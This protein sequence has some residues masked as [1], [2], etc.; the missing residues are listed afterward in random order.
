MVPGENY[1]IYGCFSLRAIPGVSLSRSL[2]LQEITAA[3]I[4]Q[5]KVIDDNMKRQI[6]N[7]SFWTCR[8]FLLT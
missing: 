3:V 6:K 2:T 4:T 8:L 1:V 5:D 7:Q